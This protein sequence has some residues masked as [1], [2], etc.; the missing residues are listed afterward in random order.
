MAGNVFQ[1]T[2]TPGRPG[3][4]ILKGCSWDDLGGICRAA[5]R[6]DRPAASRHILIGFRCRCAAGVR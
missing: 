2:A 5:A 3:R 1:W 4:F 6:H